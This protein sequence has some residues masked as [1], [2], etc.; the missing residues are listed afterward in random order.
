MLGLVVALAPGHRLPGLVACGPGDAVVD[1][2]LGGRG[3][4]PR[5]E[6]DA[7]LGDH[8]LPDRLG[9]SV[10]GGGQ[11]DH[12]SGGVGEHPVPGGTGGLGDHPRQTGGT[13]CPPD[14]T[15]G[16]S[17][18]PMTVWSGTVRLTTGLAYAGNGTPS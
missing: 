4:A 1:L 7:V 9:G 11:L 14:N 17:L 12:V 6:A 18:I 10:A 2:G 13:T 3:V 16:E 15:P 5:P 8:L